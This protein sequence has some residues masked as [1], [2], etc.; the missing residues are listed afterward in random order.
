MTKEQKVVTICCNP[1][2]VQ[3]KVD[4]RINPYLKDGWN[5]VNI[6]ASGTTETQQGYAKTISYF[7]LERKITKKK[8]NEE[9]E[10]NRR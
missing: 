5:V 3:E 9:T 2:D 6:T 8:K 7:V 4:M 1:Q 10:S